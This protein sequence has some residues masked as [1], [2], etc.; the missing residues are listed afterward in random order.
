[1]G[2]SRRYITVK[3]SLLAALTV[4]VCLADSSFSDA[5]ENAATAKTVKG[6]VSV[7]REFELIALAAGDKVKVKETIVTGADG[8]ALFA[9]AD[10]STFDVYPNS[11]VVFRNNPPNWSDF[12]DILLGK[13]RVHI[14]HLG[15]KPNHNKVYTPPAVISVRGTTFEITVD[16]EESTLV[17]VEDGV[18]EVR[19]LLRPTGQTAE[20]H[21]G[22]ALRVYRDEPIAQNDHGVFRR[23]MNLVMNALVVAARPRGIGTIP[24]GGG[25]GS[26]GIPIPGGGSTPGTVGDT[27]GGSGPPSGGPGTPPAS[28]PGAPPVVGPG[29]PP[30]SGP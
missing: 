9:V 13:V 3:L 15:N 14:E 19:H 6:S 27:S 7:Q 20:L 4:G 17:E 1:M 11:R 29:A 21:A 28:G 16:G 18:V 10:G 26:G 23:A 25:G 5:A 22:E 2:R 24:G 12:L 30:P 8:H